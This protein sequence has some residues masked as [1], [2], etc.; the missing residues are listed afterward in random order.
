MSAETPKI[1]RPPR[2]EYEASCPICGRATRHRPA[3]AIP[4]EATRAVLADGT[5]EPCWRKKLKLQDRRNNGVLMSREERANRDREGLEAYFRE[6]RNRGVPPAGNPALD[7]AYE[8][9]TAWRLD[10]PRRK[11]RAK[12]A[13]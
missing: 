11:S 9:D 2:D 8:A 5:C 7:R 12:E 4:G 10:N 6:R 3:H 1:G 13:S